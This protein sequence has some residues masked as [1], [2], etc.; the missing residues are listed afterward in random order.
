ME[1]VNG[2]VQVQDPH[3]GGADGVLRELN[4]IWNASNASIQER[5]T[6][7][8]PILELTARTLFS[9]RPTLEDIRCDDMYEQFYEFSQDKDKL[10][11][12]LQPLDLKSDPRKG[13]SAVGAS[14]LSTSASSF[15]ANG[16]DLRHMGLGGGGGGGG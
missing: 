11:Q 12:P 13:P 2:P 4:G 1:F 9:F 6:S 3:D 7:A 14:S 10:P 15:G 5:A 16:S 8:P